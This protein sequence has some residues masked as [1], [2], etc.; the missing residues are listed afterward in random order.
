[1]PYFIGV[2]AIFTQFYFFLSICFYK[3]KLQKIF[4]LYTDDKIEAVHERRILDLF[5]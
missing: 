4:R 5:S 1:M 2:L 3:L